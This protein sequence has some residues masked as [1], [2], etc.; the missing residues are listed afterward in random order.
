V[1]LAGLLRWVDD[2]P[3][4]QDDPGT[5][6]DKAKDILARPEYREPPKSLWDR[7]N[8]WLGEQIGRLLS[9]LGFGGGSVG[10]VVAWLVLAALV[11]LVVVLVMWAVRSGSWNVGRK[12][13]DE[14]DPVIV[15]TEAHRS[16]GEWLDEARRHEAEGRWNEGLLCRYRW[17][18]TNLVDRAVI[19]EQVDRTAGEY[20]RDVRRH[21][22]SIAAPFAAATELF[23]V[24]WY[25]GAAAGPDERDRFV[26]LAAE[27]LQPASVGAAP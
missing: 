17:L 4:P 8:E 3:V 26:A 22:P 18:V 11:A 9:T 21:A 13:G 6:R 2:L 15:S 19:P 23:E 14:G 12:A 20:V 25:G 10:T 1:S 7:V 24:V 16:A 5:V 27:V